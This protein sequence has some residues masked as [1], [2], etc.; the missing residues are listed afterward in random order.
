MFIAYLSGFA[1]ALAAFA[2]ATLIGLD[3]D[4]AFYS[5]VLIVIASTYV[6]FAAM[7]SDMRTLIEES[8]IFTIFLVVA[9]VGFKRNPWLIALAIA[10]HG[11]LDVTHGSIVTNGGVPPWWP[12]FCMTYD[13]TAAAFFAW[14]LRRSPA[15][16]KPRHQ[17]GS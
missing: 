14:T 10:A 12:A 7:G 16:A 11:I 15:L 4:R 6:L 1:L 13:L 8:L 2:Y 3:R 5:T 17:V 9:A